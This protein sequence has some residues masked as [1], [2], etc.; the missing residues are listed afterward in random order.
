MVHA[1]LGYQ[2]EG[3]VRTRV[4]L[5]GADYA[6]AS[7][8]FRFYEAFTERLATATGTPVV[9][10][11]WPPFFETPEQS[12]ETADGVGRGM[13]AGAIQVGS[14]YF[15][16]FRVTLRE[17]RDFV[18]AD[19]SG[20]EPVAVIS[21]TLARGLWPEGG[22]IGR[23]IRGIEQTAAGPTP[24]PWRTVVGV[25][26]DVRQTYMDAN[27]N[28]IFIPLSPASFG[29][30]GSFYMR[31][32]RTPSSLLDTIRGTAAELDP[33]AT[34]DRPRLVQSEDRQLA[35]ARFLAALLTGF[36]A[37][38]A[39][40]AILGI[41]G[42]TAYAVQQR[43][44]EMAIRM[45]VGAAG[46]AVVRIF[47]KDSALVLLIGLGAGLLGATAAGSILQNRLYAV[48]AFDLPTLLATSGLLAAA[49]ALATWWPARQACRVNPL[50]ILRE[51]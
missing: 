19:V 40:L 50:A 7:G 30:F 9:F 34:I 3:V 6:D 27:L 1:D 48:R 46:D 18:P 14:G 17:G 25:A 5:R 35:G 20:S 16:A 32:D 28:D 13:T 47:L 38:A 45:A 8:F 11:N 39:F 29:R 49:G 26:E 2:W 41:Y 36:A 4:I 51:T 33:R 44:R 12:I 23:R 21:E 37:I 10:T 24:G 31:T 15:A 43:E 42:V 22:A